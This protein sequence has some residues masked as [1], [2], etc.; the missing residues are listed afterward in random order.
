M[1]TTASVTSQSRVYVIEHAKVFAMAVKYQV[2]GLRDL[3]TTKFKQSVQTSWNHEDFA[4]ASFV[5]YDSTPE[6][7]SQLRE[8][9]ANT[10]HNHF[11]E[12]KDK[13][14]VETVVCGNPHLAY[15]LLKRDGTLPA[16]ANGHGGQ[17]TT[18]GCWDCQFNSDICKS[19]VSW[20]YCP[21]CGHGF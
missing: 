11:S 18:K 7:V 6:D 5:I 3:A 17:M 20:R 9:V 13:P 14:E 16:C 10:L 15:A 19:C 8:I 21:N 12:L 1:E 2:D 4:H